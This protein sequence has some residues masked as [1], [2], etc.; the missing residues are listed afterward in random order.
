MY[1]ERPLMCSS[2]EAVLTGLL[3][4]YSDR[5]T[6]HA[7]FVVAG[8]F[9]I[10]TVLFS[11]DHFNQNIWSKILFFFVYGALVAFNV[12][13]ARAIRKSYRRKGV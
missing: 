1:R 11:F 10:Y 5:A 3:D 2:D 7:S 4:F 9:G 8:T 12:Y 6:T 13:C